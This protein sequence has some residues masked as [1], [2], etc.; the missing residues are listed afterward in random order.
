MHSEQ[1]DKLI[2]NFWYKWTKYESLDSIHGADSDKIQ[3]EFQSYMNSESWFSKI[4][5]TP[6]DFLVAFFSMEFGIDPSL[7][8]YSG[9]LGVLAGD[10]LKSASDLGVPIIGI[11]L[12]YHNGFFQQVLDSTGR[13]SELYP[14][15]NS[16]DFPAK[17]VCD[18]S[19]H[20]LNI[21]VELAGTT[22][23]AQIWELDVG[24]VKLYLLDTDVSQNSPEFREVTARL[25]DGGRENRIRQEILLG[26]GGVRALEKM[27]IKPKLYHMT[28]GHSAFLNLERARILRN[29]YEK[30][31]HQC[32]EIL[33]KSTVFTI[34]TPVEAGNETFSLELT[35]KYFDSYIDGLGI[36]WE[37]FVELGR[38]SLQPDHYSLTVMALRMAGYCNG[39]SRLHGETSRRIWQHL[40][41]NALQNEVP[42]THITN[43]VHPRTWISNEL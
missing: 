22:I 37:Q 18:E 35:K 27:G 10:H 39:V 6:K 15:I 26:I 5:E 7:P 30:N 19:G 33:K 31:F 4:E 40:W 1:Q 43:G 28:E 2:S 13:Q 29:S 42:I 17:L 25:Y 36:N 20:P 38:D 14:R 8:I 24:R 12:Y 23:Y 32:V 3:Q 21:S 34:H 9:G 16:S 41:E 11:G